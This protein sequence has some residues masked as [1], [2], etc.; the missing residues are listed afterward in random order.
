M[1]KR[2]DHLLTSVKN[3]YSFFR[4]IFQVMFSNRQYRWHTI[5]SRSV[6]IVFC[7]SFCYYSITVKI[8]INLKPINCKNYFLQFSK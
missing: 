3:I 4:G 2:L 1:I 6:Y 7:E 5:H 8:E